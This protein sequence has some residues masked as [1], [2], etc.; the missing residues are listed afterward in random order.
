[1]YTAV[2]AMFGWSGLPFTVSK[3]FLEI[4]RRLIRQGNVRDDFAYR[5]F[6][7]VLHYLE[8]DWSDMH[9]V[10][11]ELVEQALH[12][13]QFWDVNTYRGLNC[14]RLIHQGD[15]A[16]A[17]HEIERIR[18]LADDYGY[19]FARS[20]EYAMPALLLLQ[21][22]QL[23]GALAVVER[24]YAERH[25]ELLNLFALGT[26][27]KIQLCAGDPAAV[28]TLAHAEELHRRLTLVPYYHRST[29]LQS[30][31]MFDVAALEHSVNVSSGST[32][33]RLVRRARR[34][35]RQALRMARFVARE[36]VE[37]YR[38]AGRLAWLSGE[39]ERAIQWWRK[40]ILEGERMGARPELARTH[41]E[42]GQRLIAAG[43]GDR[44]IG[45]HRAAAY[46]EHAERRLADLGLEPDTA[47]AR[48][49][50]S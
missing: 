47:V 50:E 24:Y 40:G 6:S 19:E 10:P 46:V 32:R 45:N 23:P 5:S 28:A 15:F 49:L 35:L 14:E 25:E 9:T 39:R 34:S 48:A 27:A 43:Q 16:G 31:L 44:I 7:F 26:K 1:M 22:R 21:Q 33:P 12:Y 42:L 36:R 13:G 2:A 38:L 3:R 29:L 30:R 17:R 41:L 8:G 37:V 18:Q 4:A 20:N 11:E